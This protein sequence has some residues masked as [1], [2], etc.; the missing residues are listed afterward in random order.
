M[1]TGF[2]VVCLPLV[3]VIL[4]VIALI[5]WRIVRLLS[6]VLRRSG[7]GGSSSPSPRSAVPPEQPHLL[8][9]VRVPDVGDQPVPSPVRSGIRGKRSRSSASSAHKSVS[10]RKRAGGTSKRGA[11]K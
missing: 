6:D 9:D 1:L 7:I 8:M 11:M 10:V 5:L 4:L 3:G 2:A